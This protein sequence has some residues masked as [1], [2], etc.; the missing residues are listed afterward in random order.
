MF[1]TPGAR[2]AL[3]QDE[4]RRFLTEEW[5]LTRARIERLGFVVD[6]LLDSP[7]KPTDPHSTVKRSGKS[8]E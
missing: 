6:E 8:D 4:R 2:A 5:P 1:I 3:L 7:P